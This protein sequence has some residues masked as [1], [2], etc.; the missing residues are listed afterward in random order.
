MAKQITLTYNGETYTLEYTRRTVSDMERA[1]FDWRDIKSK[2]MSTYPMLFYGAFL[3]HHRKIKESLTKEIY[4]KTPQRE[5][6][7]GKLAEMYADTLNTLFEEPEESEKNASWK[8][9]F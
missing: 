5:E 9:D 1:G 4:D 2:P 6:L 8:A 7:T 3:A